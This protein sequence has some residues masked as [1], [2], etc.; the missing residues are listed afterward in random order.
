MSSTYGRLEGE[1]LY[2]SYQ[3]KSQDPHR[4]ITGHEGDG[5]S[6]Q[7]DRGIADLTAADRLLA[8]VAAHI[9]VY[10]VGLRQARVTFH[11]GAG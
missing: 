8:Y 5:H 10:T 2:Q 6:T 4:R 1:C 9:A 11:D 7:Q 3:H